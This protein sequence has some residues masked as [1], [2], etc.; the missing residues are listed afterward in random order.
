MNRQANT[1]T[2]QNKNENL[3]FLIP[4]WN[5]LTKLILKNKKKTKNKLKSSQVR[6]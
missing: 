3:T 4:N 5:F 6:H 2:K 1:T